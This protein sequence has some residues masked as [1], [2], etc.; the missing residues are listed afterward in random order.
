MAIHTPIDLTAIGR[1]S[2][3][4]RLLRGRLTEKI[5][6]KPFANVVKT[7][8]NVTE[9]KSAPKPATP[10][11]TAPAVTAGTPTATDALNF[12]EGV[13]RLRMMLGVLPAHQRRKALPIL[14]ERMAK[15]LNPED[16]EDFRTIG[17]GLLEEEEPRKD[18]LERYLPIL[19]I[20]SMMRSG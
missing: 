1:E 15:R 4:E 5:G 16:V 11:T 9:T 7:L 6:E 13:S 10:T 20:L 14:V 2:N 3:L 8:E 17:Y 12:D 19:L 18:A